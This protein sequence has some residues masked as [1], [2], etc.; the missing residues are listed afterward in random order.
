M[1]DFR[2]RIMMG[3]GE[4][5]DLSQYA[6]QITDG[7]MVLNG[8]YAGR[9]LEF[10]C[11][12]SWVSPMSG[13]SAVLYNNLAGS[14]NGNSFTNNGGWGGRI[15]ITLDG[16]TGFA[17]G[18]FPSNTLLHIIVTCND[19]LSFHIT[20]ENVTTGV[21]SEISGTKHH[22]WALY[23]YH[24]GPQPQARLSLISWKLKDISSGQY[25]H[26]LQ[27]GKQGGKYGMIDIDNGEFY[28]ADG[29]ELVK[30]KNL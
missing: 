9:Q 11:Y 28:T 8:C 2:R 13:D 1:S 10:Y 19:D 27:L 22:A 18:T 29:V 7:E 6:L 21:T 15:T 20:T 4:S 5:I 17:I 26:N 16:Y 14:F 3:Q 12:Y 30:Y 25:I 24:F 23:S